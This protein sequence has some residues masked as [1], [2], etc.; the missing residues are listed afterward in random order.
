MALIFDARL[1]HQ[2]HKS[3]KTERERESTCQE[4]A[5]NGFPLV[6]MPKL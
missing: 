5:L 1:I 3:A 6:I 4:I 2:H